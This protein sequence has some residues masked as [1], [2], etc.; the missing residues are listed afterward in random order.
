MSFFARFMLDMMAE[1]PTHS[2]KNIYEKIEK[3]KEEINNEKKCSLQDI[4]N[5]VVKKMFCENTGSHPLDSGGVYG[6]GWQHSQ[7]LEELDWT[8]RESIT[9]DFWETKDKV[10]LSF[11][12]DTYTFLIANLFYDLALD[13]KFHEFCESE[14]M[15]K[16]SYYTCAE[17]FT[18]QRGGNTYNHDLTLSRDFRFWIEGNRE[19]WDAKFVIISIH[20][21]CDI[22]GGY[23]TPHVFVP[24]DGMDYFISN[25]YDMHVR[26]PNKEEYSDD[27]IDG[28]SDDSGYHWY[29]KVDWEIVKAEDKEWKVVC[30]VCKAEVNFYGF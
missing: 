1:K 27:H 11:Y 7:E 4:T 13:K 20:N 14:E 28:Y 17:K 24:Q 30:P 15:K 25:L 10:E 9:L 29:E 23:S 18:G 21:G 2:T 22:R 26:C 6:R 12:K 19:I 8:E 3:A 16:K 5:Y